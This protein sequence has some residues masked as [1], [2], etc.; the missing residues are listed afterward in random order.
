MLRRVAVA[1]LLVLLACSSKHQAETTARP[2]PAS[3]LGIAPQA[4]GHAPP[5]G[6]VQI[7]Y[8]AP[9][10]E[11][12]GPAEISV[13]FDRPMI[14]LGRDAAEP[15]L[16]SI[17]PPIAGKARWVGSQTLLF[18]PSDPLPMGTA[19][20]VT[21]AAGVRALDGQA[22]VDALAFDFATPPLAVVRTEPSAG[23]T[24]VV[25]TSPLDL[26]FNQAVAPAALR[27]RLTLRVRDQRGEHVQEV[28]V[29]RIDPSDPRRV[30]VTPKKPLPLGATVTVQV[31]AG[32]V[33]EEGPRALAAPH[34][35]QF[36]V[37]GPLRIV[38][39]PPCRGLDCVAKL[40]FTNPV[41]VA[42]LRTS[43]RFDPPLAA[44]LSDTWDHRSESLYFGDELAPATTYKVT[45]DGPVKDVYGNSL[46][47]ARTALVRTPP[48]S[49]SARVLMDGSLMQAGAV[50]RLRVALAN[51]KDAR[52][53]L[54]RLRAAEVLPLAVDGIRAKAP[55]SVQQIGAVGPAERRIVDVDLAPALSAGRG[56]V[57]V[58]VHARGGG[59]A[60]AE[61]ALFAV[62]DLAPT[63]KAGPRDGVVW[64]TRLSDAQPVAGAAVRIVD[65][66]RVLAAGTT[67]G[68]GLFRFVRPPR[69]DA[70]EGEV[71]AIVEHAGD[72][73]FARSYAGVGPWEL[74][75]N[76]GGGAGGP[77]SAHLFTER[78]IYR[79]GDQLQLKGI[80][81][82]S[83]SAGFQPSTGDLTLV[84]LDAAERELARETLHLSAFGTFAYALR[85]P[86]SAPLG[87]ISLRVAHAGQT[88]TT[89]AEVA[90]YRP[91]EL[92]VAL[93][94][95]R[96]AYVRGER[97][98]ARVSGRFLFGAPASEGRSF[99]SARA[100]RREFAPAGYEGF[101]FHDD[102][103]REREEP[104][105]APIIASG[106]VPL[107]ADGVHP[108]HVA[109]KN[110]PD[111]G[112]TSLALEATVTAGGTEA[113][114]RT[115]VSLTPA[116]VLA[117]ISTKSMVT[118][119]DVPLDL[120]LV[121][122]SPD[123]LPARGVVLEGTLDKRVFETVLVDGR[124]ET[125]ARDERVASCRKPSAGAPVSCAVQPRDP[126]L[127]IARVS[128]RDAKGRRSVASLAIYV[129]G[130]GAAAWGAQAGPVFAPKA[131]R[132]DYALGETAHIL[133]PSPFVEAEALI[134][135]EREGV[136]SVARQ[137][138]GAASTID[139]KIDERFVPNAFVT[140]LLV[141]ALADGKAVADPPYRVG[142]IALAADVSAR[143]LAV[144]VQPDAADKRPGDEVALTLDVRDGNGKP[145]PAELTVFAVDEGVLSLSGYRTPDPFSALYA[146]RPLSVWTADAR[147]SLSRLRSG[148]DDE[149]GGGEGGGG[150]LM[151][152]QNF[153]AVALYAPGVETDAAGRA[154]LRFKLPDGTTRYRIMAVAASRGAEVGAG[155]SFV[156]THK[157]LLLRPLLPRV[158]RAGD[159]LAAGVAVHNGAAR[160]L[161]VAVALT[162]QG[163][164]V[165]GPRARTVRVPAGGVA[166]LRFPVR[167]E[168]VGE[169][170]LTF[171]AQA[172][173]ER[174]DVAAALPVRTPAA[175][176][177]VIVAGVAQAQ[178]SE[179]LA[180]LSGVRADI[181]GLTLTLATSA[182]AELEQ[183]A[184]ALLAYEYGCTEQLSSRLVAL[185][186]LERLRVPLG[187]SDAPFAP[188]AGPLLSEL[189]RHQRDDG[190]FGM[191]RA[192]ERTPAPLA[193]F[194]TGYALIAFEQLAR[195]G[196]APSAHAREA[197]VRFL[198]GYLRRPAS[199]RA[200]L[201]DADR[202]FVL[203]ALARAHGY[204]PAYGAT[205]FE[206]RARLP[207]FA[208]VELALALTHD[209]GAG[210]RVDELVEAL[211]ADVRVT[212]DEAH[213]EANVRDQHAP[214]MVSDVR[215]TAGL[216]LLLRAHAPDH[217]LAPK[218]ARWLSG[219][220]GREGSWRSTQESAW[221]LMALA[222]YFEAEQPRRT[223]LKVD[224]LLGTVTLGRVHLAGARAQASFQRGMAELP[225]QG[226]ALTLNPRGRGALHYVMRLAYAPATL[227]SA[228]R[229]R[230]FFVERSY[231]RIDP[232]ALARG[233][234]SGPVGAQAALS[235]Y[236]RVNLRIA[237]PAARRFVLIADPLPAG[238]EPVDFNLATEVSGIGLRMG[239]GPH[240]HYE[241]RDDRAVFAVNDLPAGL[242]RYSYL[243][244]ARSAGEFVAPPA[245]VEEMYH[246][247]TQG[248]T[249]AARFRVEAAP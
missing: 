67:D 104:E 209:Q 210:A 31:A 23:D 166:E 249:P 139:V 12:A 28:L 14:A 73:A 238:L 132:H 137:R 174:D 53:E 211:R 29:A 199:E 95:A 181:G 178:V 118:S 120:A 241:L 150:G 59:E 65:E 146:P 103:R 11:L 206:A 135:V 93:D 203:Y 119:R 7:T 234:T 2:G 68:D 246:P 44:P 205:L 136:L 175:L 57:L 92:E 97:A 102:E 63:L 17:S 248:L 198:A 117:G 207:V 236:V 149:K 47:G 105:D 86:G 46:E 235:D 114:G 147:A 159:L 242:Y 78:G 225:V 184:R 50:P 196:I 232:A 204:D 176:E 100:V 179:A 109:L 90:E 112:P 182:L 228:P 24:G 190:S 98:E 155:E 26:Y 110:A 164:V 154:T 126:G 185:S 173:D 41:S 141:P 214:L 36:R 202:A 84:A 122:L 158:L 247:E 125:K 74:T 56:V 187:L 243:A 237:V 168:R 88:F 177:T 165:D 25:R 188:L 61:H 21:V 35:T 231:E 123:G 19:F 15:G 240:D 64:V 230:G 127:H 76:A 152:R 1:L 43:L 111:Y 180:P 54:T 81:R 62:T 163:L 13:S 27:E 161:D 124:P 226:A 48:L 91:A 157:P 233:E 30:R 144:T 4:D 171:V 197:A 200:G 167:A 153:A 148:D 89:E 220:R 193:A 224:A 245:R 58:G 101:V 219:A 8:F 10:G 191:W 83:T 218:L 80:M 51:L 244:R 133:V 223:D 195:A 221:A 116:G 239:Q 22:L 71:A 77:V 108:L 49:P 34:E 94:V 162:A 55:P 130:S 42:A 215:A 38:P 85:I 128:A 229:E 189:E 208:R 169:A 96:P 40:S 192:D 18:S 222:D 121:A 131:A 151:V 6:P 66:A 37:Y 52:I 60:F 9:V 107:D 70:Q 87:P 145:T 170:R 217:V 156:R 20:R 212:A 129:S 172:G 16:L 75:D 201:D 183:P 138:V 106:E 72:L 194:L 160:P 39:N 32:L 143:R 3:P 140:V 99:W 227:P 115:R 5:R 79:P 45:I 142:T 186:A 213:V 69:G 216:L 33:G 134:S 113:T 82:T